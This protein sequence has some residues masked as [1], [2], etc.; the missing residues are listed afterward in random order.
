[1]FGILYVVASIII[2]IIFISIHNIE[3][4]FSEIQGLKQEIHLLKEINT[5]LEAI[6]SKV[7]RIEEEI[8]IFKLQNIDPI[9][10]NVEL[11]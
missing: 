3:Q 9:V 4:N 2:S 11:L 8:D 6:A 1:M 10:K 7:N 5:V